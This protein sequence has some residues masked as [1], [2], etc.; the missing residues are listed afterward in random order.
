MY[1]LYHEVRVMLI[2]TIFDAKKNTFTIRIIGSLNFNSHKLFRN[3][4]EQIMPSMRFIYLDLD[5][6]FDI[7]VAGLGLLLILLDRTKKY[8]QKVKIINAQSRILDVLNVA[9]I[10]Q[11][12]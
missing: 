10:T 3:A 11:V 5:D 6:T 8:Q 1:S 4:T 9:N 12:F 2:D 7:D